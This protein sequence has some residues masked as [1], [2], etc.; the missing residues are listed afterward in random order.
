M[1]E[2]LIDHEDVLLDTPF[3]RR[4]REEARAEGKAQGVEE[5]M[6]VAR[7]R[8]I[9]DVL[10]ARFDP[11]A[12]V[13]RQLEQHL[14]TITEEHRLVDLLTMAIRAHNMA[15]FQAAIEPASSSRYS[16]L[17]TSWSGCGRLPMTFVETLASVGN[18]PLKIGEGPES[19]GNPIHNED[20]AA[21]RR[22]AGREAVR[23][24]VGSHCRAC[25]N[26][27]DAD[28]T[29]VIIEAP[30]GEYLLHA[31]GYRYRLHDPQL[32]GRPDIVF[33][34]R[35]KV[36]F[37]HGC[38]WHRHGCSRAT[39]PIS[40]RA[41]WGSKRFERNVW[42]G[43]QANQDELHAM[44]WDVLIVWECETKNRAG[45]SDLC[46]W[47]VFMRLAR[48]PLMKAL[49]THL[50]PAQF[51]AA[52][53]SRA[54]GVRPTDG[55]LTGTTNLP[56]P[57]TTTSRIPT[58]SPR[59]PG[60]LGRS[61]RC[62]TRPNCSP[63]FLPTASSPTQVHCQRLRVAALAL[64]AW[65]HSGTSTSKPKRRSRLS[66]ERL[67]SAPSRRAGRF[68]SQPRTW[69]S[70]GVGAAPD[71]S[72]GH[73]I[74]TILPKSCCWLCKRPAISVTRSLGSPRSSRACWKALAACCN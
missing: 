15:A 32:P 19:N 41:Y 33:R 68:L 5:G 50:Y 60:V 40:N 48:L 42:L 1:V 43:D 47:L 71:Q 54:C 44:D 66:Q 27:Y 10:V 45:F 62:P 55:K 53:P 64:A 24:G 58:R 37:V 52:R 51:V 35:R 36:L 2:R 13:Y 56:S 46:V 12:S 11:Q 6:L 30:M 65:R 73:I 74:P 34:R 18:F 49:S 14:E 38:F 8:S 3:L 22:E 39:T 63:Y 72:G 25:S 17:T 70:F 29:E 59:A 9:L 4:L 26:S 61:T 28:A 20:F 21:H 16:G 7:R 67:G 23:Q 57:M 69:H 31:L